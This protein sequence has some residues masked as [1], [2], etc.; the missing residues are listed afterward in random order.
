MRQLHPIDQMQRTYE[1]N[2][3]R[4]ND[5]RPR[6]PEPDFDTE[7]V[8]MTPIT[9]QRTINFDNLDRKSVV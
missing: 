8:H 7:P 2:R 6:R 3:D 1:R 5:P 9:A 4:D